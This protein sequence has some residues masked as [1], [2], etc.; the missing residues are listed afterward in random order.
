MCFSISFLAAEFNSSASLEA[1]SS[2]S[3]GLSS[4]L[5]SDVLSS[6]SSDSLSSLSLSLS[7]D[8]SS[9]PFS[10]ST[11]LIISSSLPSLSFLSSS[12]SAS[13]SI[14]STPESFLSSESFLP[15]SSASSFLSFASSESSFSSESSSSDSLAFS[16]SQ[17]SLP[18]LSHVFF[19]SFFSTSL[20]SFFSSS[21]SS[22]SLGVFMSPT[23]IPKAAA[24][25]FPLM[26]SGLPTVESGFAVSLRGLLISS[27][28]SIC[29]FICI[30]FASLRRTTGA[31]IS[32]TDISSFKKPYCGAEF[33]DSNL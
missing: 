14:I 13:T 29:L 32:E 23:G 19:S 10:A 20:V 25:P 22:A 4:S 8:L 6:S 16:H 5:A 1:L 28:I 21:D 11:S 18:H 31:L 27:V 30:S 3:R 2:L 15:P 26:L 9:D 33:I 24:P 17:G 7:S 12:N